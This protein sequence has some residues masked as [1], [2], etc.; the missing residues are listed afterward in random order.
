MTK[1]MLEVIK[2]S[3]LADLYDALEVEK[4][5]EVIQAIKSEIGARTNES[6]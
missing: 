4:D 5:A 1:D 3:M 6:I 2:Y